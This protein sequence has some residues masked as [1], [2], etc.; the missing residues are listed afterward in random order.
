M[1][2]PDPFRFYKFNRDFLFQPTT[3]V[4]LFATL[5]LPHR[6]ASSFS[7]HFSGIGGVS[8]PFG[9][10]LARFIIRLP[11]ELSQTVYFQ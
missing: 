9:R 7:N 10:V 3:R 11:Q 6:F 2:F 8:L 5:L 4:G 1:R